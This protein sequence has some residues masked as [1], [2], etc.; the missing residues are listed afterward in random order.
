MVLFCGLGRVRASL[1]RQTVVSMRNGTSG[2][3]AFSYNSR[4]R[5]GLIVGYRYSQAIVA[6]WSRQARGYFYTN[7]FQLKALIFNCASVL[8]LACFPKQVL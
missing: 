5:V 2:L 3:F 6:G 8:T 7:H 4:R 1:A